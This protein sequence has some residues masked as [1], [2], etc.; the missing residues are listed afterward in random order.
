MSPPLSVLTPLR[1]EAAAVRRGAPGAAVVVRGRGP[2]GS[3]GAVAAGARP[4][5]VGV[6]FTNLRPH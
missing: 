1:V 2:G 6:S 5:P 4:G 3:A